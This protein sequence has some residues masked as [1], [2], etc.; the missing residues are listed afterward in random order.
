MN[1]IT[2]H[3][4]G[5]EYPNPGGMWDII[6]GTLVTE[7]FICDVLQKYPMGGEHTFTDAMIQAL[8]E[9]GEMVLT[10]TVDWP[11]ITKLY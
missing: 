1:W 3:L 2:H 7:D 4:A 5:R 6:L 11:V 9:K 8:K 10:R